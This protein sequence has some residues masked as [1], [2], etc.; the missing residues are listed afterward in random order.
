[1]GLRSGSQIVNLK[2]RKIL[3]MRNLKLGFCYIAHFSSI[4]PFVNLKV[5]KSSV[6]DSDK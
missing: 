5:G 6:V 2:C 3:K 4:Q 1:M